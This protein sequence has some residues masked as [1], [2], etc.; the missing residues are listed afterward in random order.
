MATEPAEEEIPSEFECTICMKLLLDPVTVPCGH[1]FCKA[2]LEKSLGYRGVCAICRSPIPSGQ[3]VNVLIR[4]IISERYPQTYALR[5]REQDEELRESENA[6]NEER[7]REVTAGAPAGRDGS[8]APV[9]PLLR[10]VA[11]HQQPLPH[12]RAEIDLRSPEEERLLEYALQGGRR[13]G[14]LLHEGERPLGV[15]LEIEGV[16]RNPPR[17]QQRPS[18]HGVGK[19]RFWLTEA[20]HI[21]DDGF[22]LGRCEAF[23]D[24]PLAPADLR[25]SEESLAAMPE[26]PSAEEVAAED[27]P[28]CRQE[29]AAA[30]ARSASDLIQHQ[31]TNI[32]QGGRHVFVARH[33]NTPPISTGHAPATTTSA[34]LEHLSFWLLGALRT[35]SNQRLDWIRS[36]D[37]HARLEFCRETLQAAGSRPVL[38]LP[39]ASSWMNPGQSAFGSFALL[40]AI[41]LLFVVKAL[42]IF[43]GRSRW[44][45][46]GQHVLEE[47]FAFGQLLR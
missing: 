45:G 30:V 32:G 28:Q 36:I 33:G 18:V 9:L 21:H 40:V 19:Y 13:I 39:G 25:L 42:G 8:T 23:F 11:S 12:C 41:L 43:D 29:R 44:S 6:A 34:A 4:S 20:A 46:A 1:T 37:T 7:H 27:V 16:E 47:T 31:L 38:D 15:C 17:L 24:A 5:L 35:Q 3:G 10:G 22:E 26:Q 14:I 2:C